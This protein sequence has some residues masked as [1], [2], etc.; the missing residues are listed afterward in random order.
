MVHTILNQGSKALP[1]TGLPVYDNLAHLAQFRKDMGLGRYNPYLC[2][3]GAVIPFQVGAAS[4]GGDPS[5]TD[6]KIVNALTGVE[7]DLSIGLLTAE[8]YNGSDYLIT[9]DGGTVPSLARG[10]YYFRIPLND[11][12]SLYTEVFTAC[13]ERANK[14]LYIKWF[15]TR[16]WVDGAYYGAGYEN[17]LWVESAFARPK[18]EYAEE[19]LE[20]GY[21][22]QLPVYQRTEEVYQF[23][24]LACDSMVPLLYKMAHH[25]T[26][27]VYL[28]PLSMPY[29]VKSMRAT[30]TGER[31][32]ALAVVNMA[33]KVGKVESTTLD[34]V[35]YEL[36]AC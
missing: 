28:N 27:R 7:T 14:A 21:G 19:V 2:D 24:I 5:P 18:V 15:D 8:C 1:G 30:D 25:N 17:K 23:D 13:S 3:Q 36:G 12:R 20:D 29:E 33:F 4:Q 16:D 11:S 35:T 10:S 26:V 6:F 9:Y 22:Y 34:A 32:D 31:N